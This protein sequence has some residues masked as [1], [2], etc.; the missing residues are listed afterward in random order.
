VLGAERLGHDGAVGAETALHQRVRPLAALRLADDARD[1]EVALQAKAGPADGLGG[2]DD[3]GH[4]ALHVL[5]AVAVQPVALER[6]RPG[7]ALPSTRQRV[8]VGVPVQHQ[9]GAAA[10]AGQRGDRL[11]APGLDLLQLDAVVA[12]AEERGEEARDGRL[13]VL[14]LGMRMSVLARPIRSAGSTCAS[15][16][17]CA[18]RSAMVRRSISQRAFDSGAPARLASVH[19]P[20]HPRDRHYPAGVPDDGTPSRTGRARSATNLTQ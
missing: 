16:R 7:L 1:H 19:G 12:L 2:H 6:G 20:E 17:C 3:A 5:D 8:D 11:E 15:T 9:A 4:A 13:P 10:R 18:A 14:K